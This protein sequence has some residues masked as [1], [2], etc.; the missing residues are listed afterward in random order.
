MKN[1]KEKN[2]E[3]KTVENQETGTAS[4]SLAQNP[5]EEKQRICLYSDDTSGYSED[6]YRECCDME[7]DEEI[8]YSSFW[9]WVNDSICAYWED[10]MHECYKNMPD[11]AVLITGTSGLWDGT[12]EIVPVIVRGDEK[13]CAL[14]KAIGMCQV[15]GQSDT[16]VWLEPDGT[17]SINVTHHDG[18]NHKTV[19]LLTDRGLEIAEDIEEYGDESE[20]RP[21]QIEF[22]PFKIEHFWGEG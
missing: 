19:R 10:F 20:Y 9:A 18:F 14:V 3:N 21:E 6:E 17:V 4:E 1:K 5:Q 7:P 15:N 16:E 22:E 8:N 11:N 13:E 2:T 12:H